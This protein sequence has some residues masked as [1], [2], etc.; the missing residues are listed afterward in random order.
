MVAESAPRM[1]RNA[2]IWLP[3][4]LTSP[5]RGDF[6]SP[7]HI[8][9]CFCDHYEPFWAKPSLDVAQSR[10]QHWQE[11]YPRMA[12]QF[13]DADGRPPQH[14]FFFPA[15][16]YRSEF[17]ERL[18]DLCRKGYGETEIHLHH[19]ND[20]AE[21]LTVTLRDF[22]RKLQGHGFLSRDRYGFIHGNWSLDNSRN[23]GRW[24]GVNNELQVLRNT[25]CYADFT[26][27]SA[28][29]ETQTHKINS[30][31]YATDDSQRPKSHDTG[32][33]VRVGG[34]TSGDLMI[35]QGPLA[36]NWRRRKWG[37]LP[38]IEAGNIAG[39]C[40]VTDARVDLWVRQGIGVAGKP[41]W[42]FV[43]VHTHGCQEGNFDAVMDGRLHQSL[44]RYND[45]IRFRLHYVTA[46]EMFNLVKAAEAGRTGD[47]HQYRDFVLP[48]PPVRGGFG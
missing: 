26:L 22:K 3:A 5:R 20:T 4:Y 36:L 46:R 31:Y 23:D 2:H 47:P 39:N 35:I 44:Q 40:R 18:A 7:T 28:P 25:G 29:S 8:L 37:V 9:F 34:H 12:S 10:V 42:I 13:R 33:D 17:L 14:S 27:P 19:D 43:K 38:R 24:C 16:E 15:E 6:V 32:I 11:R 30:I 48:P 45:G 41:D 1:M 21:N